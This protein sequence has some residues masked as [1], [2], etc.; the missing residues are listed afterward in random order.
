ML[1]L[2][3]FIL[4]LVFIKRDAKKSQVFKDLMLLAYICFIIYITVLRRNSGQFHEINLQPLWS[5]AKF[6]QTDIRW[7]IYMNIFLFIP[8]GFFLGWSLG[9][10]FWKIVGIAFLASAAIEVSQYIFCIGLCEVDDMIHNTVGAMIGY[11]FWS[12]LDCCY[13]IKN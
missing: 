10:R 2:V 12:V 13:K 4:D 8:L 1:P 5:W 3:I 6:A 7:Q 11:G 9:L